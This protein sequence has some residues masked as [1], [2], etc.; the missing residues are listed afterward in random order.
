MKK[1]IVG[2]MPARLFLD[3]FF[4]SDKISDYRKAKFV[5]G[6]YDSTVNAETQ[7]K[8]YEPFVSRLREFCFILFITIVTF[9]NTT[10]RQYSH[11][12]KFVNSSA[13]TDRNPRSK[14][15]F[16]VKPDVSVYPD[17]VNNNVK[18]DSALVEIFIEFKWDLA[19]DPFCDV[20]KLQPDG[21]S[22]ITDSMKSHDTLG[23]ITSYAAAQLGA[24]FRT[25]IFAVLI[26]KDTARLLRW[27]RAGTIVTEAF[28][29]NACDI[30]TEFFIRYSNA[31]PA[32]RGKDETV[33]DPSPTEEVLA[34]RV[35]DL[36]KT[37]PL[38]KLSIPVEDGTRYFVTSTPQTTPYTPPGRATRGFKAYDVLRNKMV[39]V[40]DSWRIDLPD[41]QAEGIVYKTLEGAKVRNIACCIASGDI[42]LEE[43]HAT[44]TQIYATKPWSTC[45][46]THFISHRHYRLCLDSVGRTLL[47]FRSS[48]EMVTAV[49]DALIGEFLQCRLS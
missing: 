9:K 1:Y 27:D 5:V 24:Q 39:Y 15:S 3:D 2:P 43:Y 18:T 35:L 47:E 22:F 42:S 6:C 36:D 21:Q 40:K 10:S 34:R 33:S 11:N 29:Y 14:F 32:M 20:P 44:K 45:S 38:V 4:P 46:A 7:H 49:R 19:E 12:L 13:H 31:E 26:I 48:Y 37:V 30:L 8:A 16:K 25:H 41:I 28:K 23:Q 17:T